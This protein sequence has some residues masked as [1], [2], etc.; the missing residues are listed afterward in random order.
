M[1]CIAAAASAG[2]ERS[3]EDRTGLDM[4]SNATG[5]RDERLGNDPEQQN[6]GEGS[7][8]EEIR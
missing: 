5:E 8:S 4:R 7:S 3:A 2:C 1:I 6:T